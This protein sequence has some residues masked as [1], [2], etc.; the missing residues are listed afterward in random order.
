MDYQRMPTRILLL[1]LAD[2]GIRER[3]WIDCERLRQPTE[4]TDT[5]DASIV[6][7][8]AHELADRID[9]PRTRP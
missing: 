7:D 9:K 4:Y 8:V 3:R 2:R 1:M 5:H 6:G